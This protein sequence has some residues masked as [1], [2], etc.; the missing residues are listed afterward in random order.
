MK[1]NVTITC[2]KGVA[3]ILASELRAL[4][5]EPI[6]EDVAAVTVE[7]DL[8]QQMRLLLRLRSAHRVLVPLIS[9]LARSPQELFRRIENFAWEDHLGP[10]GYVRIHGFVKNDEIRDQRFAFLTVKD[11]VMDRLRDKYGRRPDSGPSDHGASIYIHWLYEEVTLSLDLAGAPLSRRG[12]R[13]R[14]GEAP[15]QEALAAAMLLAGGWPKDVALCNPMGG[16]GTIA[17][18]A[19]WL[20]QNRAP[21]LLRD[22]FGLF[23]LKRFQPMMWQ[24]EVEAAESEI[25]PEWEVP[26]II[27]SDF[28]REVIEIAKMNAKEAGVEK[29]I[30]FEVCDF[31]ETPVPEGE[32]WVVINPPYGIRLEEED[33]TGLYQDIGQWLKSL[34]RKGQGLVITANLP[35]AKRFGLK[36]AQKHTLFNGPLECRL[37]GFELQKPGARA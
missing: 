32:S 19:A 29:L 17:I 10:D 25:I 6:S 33:L 12:Y 8:Q 7:A 16:S 5:L 20:A 30:Q 21:G 28:D 11:A 35:L 24:K 3:P 1:E 9:C 31:R 22:H 4:G 27:C 36:L 23:S 37:L 34:D 18:E 2:A 26:V 13:S 14:A 15:L